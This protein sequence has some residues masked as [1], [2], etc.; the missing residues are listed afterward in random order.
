MICIEVGGLKLRGQLNDT[1]CARAVADA[2]PLQGHFDV[3]GDEFYFRVP[4][5]HELERTAKAEMEVGDLGYWPLGNALCIFF[6]PTPMSGG[7]K[8]VAA[9]PVNLVG[10]VEGA[11]LL[12]G[13][14]GASEITVEATS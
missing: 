1:D 10:S 12:K 7:E 3:W 11:E 4:V 9:S 13:A 2:L 14:K 5:E 8:P 6:G